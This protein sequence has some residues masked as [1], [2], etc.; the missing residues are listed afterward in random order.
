MKNKRRKLYLEATL[1]QY[2]VITRSQQHNLES[3]LEPFES[4]QLVG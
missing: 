2:Q 3:V 1:I 4:A